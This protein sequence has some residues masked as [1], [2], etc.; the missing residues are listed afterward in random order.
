MRLHSFLRG[1][2]TFLS[3]DD[4]EHSFHGIP[5]QRNGQHFPQGKWNITATN[6]DHD[7]FPRMRRLWPQLPKPHNSWTPIHTTHTTSRDF[8]LPIAVPRHHYNTHTCSF[9]SLPMST[10]GCIFLM[11]S[12]LNLQISRCTS[13]SCAL[14]RASNAANV[15]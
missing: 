4:N 11:N 1:T 5:I 3:S 14:R 6:N 9:C 7:M 15:A 2:G 8:S 10:P 12:S 13:V